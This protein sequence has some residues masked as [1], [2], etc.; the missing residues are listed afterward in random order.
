MTGMILF[1]LILLTAI[2]IG[3]PLRPT[4]AMAQ[5]TRTPTEGEITRAVRRLRQVSFCPSC[6][7]AIRAGARFCVGCGRALSSPQPAGS[8]ATCGACGAFVREEDRFC[9]HCGS[10][11]VEGG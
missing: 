2:G 11:V 1:F 7:A 5:S 10:P 8:G 6:G 4:R 3:Y 9:A